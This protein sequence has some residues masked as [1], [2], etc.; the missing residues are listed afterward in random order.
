STDGLSEVQ[1]GRRR[2]LGEGQGSLA[3]NIHE[4]K[5]R[6]QGGDRKPPDSNKHTRIYPF[7]IPSY[8]HDLPAPIYHELYQNA[9][10]DGSRSLRPH[11]P[12][13]LYHPHPENTSLLPPK[14]TRSLPKN[15]KS[16]TPTPKHRQY[17]PHQPA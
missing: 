6:E 16:P 14:T 13:G 7:P 4:H 12:L 10:Y 17:V 9:G 1:K 3:A 5:K 2:R 15:L 8:N 11:N